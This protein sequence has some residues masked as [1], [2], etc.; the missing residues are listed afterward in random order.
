MGHPFRLTAKER[1]LPV[2]EQD[3]D[4]VLSRFGWPWTIDEAPKP[5]ALDH[6]RAARIE[7]LDAK[8][9]CDTRAMG[10]AARKLGPLARAALAPA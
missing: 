3:V 9:R 4:A 2:S 8:A 5:T 10:A 6:W 7:Y 1:A